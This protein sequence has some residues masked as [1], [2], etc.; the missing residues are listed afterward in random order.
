MIV[1]PPSAYLPCPPP[2][3]SEDQADVRATE[4]DDALNRARWLLCAL[5]H[6]AAVACLEARDKAI[7]QTQPKDD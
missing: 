3:I 7:Q 6:E 2:Q 4:V 1:C 5:R